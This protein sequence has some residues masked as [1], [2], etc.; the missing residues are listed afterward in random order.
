MGLSE[1]QEKVG[2][3]KIDKKV[4]KRRLWFEY[5]KAAVTVAVFLVGL[6]LVTYFIN[7]YFATKYGYIFD[8]RPGYR[9]LV[10]LISIVAYIFVFASGYKILGF[11]ITDKMDELKTII[12]RLD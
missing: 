8:E 4:A 12:D 6:A 7:G 9:N 2:Q 5:A 1:V 10:L 3:P 11:K